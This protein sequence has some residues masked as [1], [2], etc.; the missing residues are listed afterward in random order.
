MDSTIERLHRRALL[1]SRQAAKLWKRSKQVFE[2]NETDDR[3][4]KL[5]SAIQLNERAIDECRKAIN[6]I[7]FLRRYRG[8][9]RR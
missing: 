1:H 2:T 9:R 8:T 7:D 5:E 6:T 4:I 3:T